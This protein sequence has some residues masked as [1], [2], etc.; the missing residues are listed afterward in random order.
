M[1]I[2]LGRCHRVRKPRLANRQVESRWPRQPSGDLH[3][4][5]GNPTR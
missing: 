4:T 5:M 2:P 1:T 3:L